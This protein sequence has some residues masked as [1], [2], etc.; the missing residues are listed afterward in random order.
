MSERYLTNSDAGL[1]YADDQPSYEKRRRPARCSVKAPV[2]RALSQAYRDSVERCS[3]RSGGRPSGI[4]RRI[5][6]K[7][8]Y[9]IG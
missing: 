4:H 3:H 6:K 5:I 7:P 2:R 8:F 9:G 1:A